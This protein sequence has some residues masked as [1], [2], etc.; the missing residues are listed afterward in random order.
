MASTVRPLAVLS[1]AARIVA[2]LKRVNRSEDL[3]FGSEMVLASNLQAVRLS[4]GASVSNRSD[5]N[6]C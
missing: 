3:T 1:A 2:A 5:P 6:E 4:N